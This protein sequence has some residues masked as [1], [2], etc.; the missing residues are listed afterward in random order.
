MARYLPLP[1][2]RHIRLLRLQSSPSPDE[3]NGTL[4]TASLDDPE[5]EIIHSYHALSYVWGEIDSGYEI[6]LNGWSC[7]IRKNLWSF[8]S[9]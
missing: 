6:I 7:S 3:I 8:F 5:L 4:I 9:H 2:S 1:N